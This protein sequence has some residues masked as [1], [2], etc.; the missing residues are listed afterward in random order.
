MK[1]SN[2]IGSYFAV[3]I[4]VSIWAVSYVFTAQALKDFRPLSIITLRISLAVL[5]MF[6]YAKATKQLQPMEKKDRRF[7]IL[8]GMIQPFIYFVSETYGLQ[9]L[10]PTLASVMLSTMPLFAPFFAYAFLREKFTWNNIVGIVVS[11]CG[12]MLLI[13]EKEQLVVKPLGIVLVIICITTAILYNVALRK[14]PSHYNNVSIVFYV[15]LSS[16]LFFYP[17]WCLVDLPHIHEMTFSWTAFGSVLV[18]ALFASTTA[19]ILYAGVVRTIGI[20]RAAAFS[21]L[22][23]GFTALF[24]WIM[25]GESLPW[26]KWVG[27]SI[28]ILGLFVSQISFKRKT[29]L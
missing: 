21:N 26:I 19:Y 2:N 27:I 17:T 29:S 8:T 9:L 25:F 13:F 22:Q 11:L 5:F 12:V 14:V 4:A 7:F 23:P 20:T 18:L 3:I 24:V 6:I 16:L 1:A 28:V 15:H 10:S